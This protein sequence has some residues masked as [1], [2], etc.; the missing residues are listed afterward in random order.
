MP[1]DAGGNYTLPGGNP[2]VTGTVITST[3]A[4]PTMS[5]IANEITNSLSRNGQ[6][7]MLGRYVGAKNPPKEM[8]S[9]VVKISELQSAPRRAGSN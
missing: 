6:G 5:D 9:T 3:W 2:V 1:R 4:N 8:A 7:G